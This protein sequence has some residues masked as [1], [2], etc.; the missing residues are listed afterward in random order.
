[1][2]LQISEHLP[3]YLLLNIERKLVSNKFL[4]ELINPPDSDL[5]WPPPYILF[6]YVEEKYPLATAI[7]NA[8][9]PLVIKRISRIISKRY[10]HFG[11]FTA[12]LLKSIIRQ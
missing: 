9:A 10:H 8:N 11:Y 6:F 1:M 12:T 2:W 7:N 5:K 3:T 4:N